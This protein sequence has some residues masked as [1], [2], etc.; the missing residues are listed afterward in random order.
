MLRA[1]RDELPEK[2]ADWVPRAELELAQVGE[3]IALQ[4]AAEAL[5]PCHGMGCGRCEDCHQ[6][7][8]RR[9]AEAVAVHTGEV[10]GSWTRED[11]TRLVFDDLDAIVRGMR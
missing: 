11:V 3:R 5:A 2:G 7:E 8:L 1:E 4:R 10:C 9:V 6:A